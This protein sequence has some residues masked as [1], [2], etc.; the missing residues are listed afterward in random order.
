MCLGRWMDRLFMY[1]CVNVGVC[2]Q[3]LWN[4][5]CWHIAAIR[6]YA[7]ANVHTCVR[8]AC[9]LHA[10]HDTTKCT[11]KAQSLINSARKQLFVKVL[12]SL[13]IIAFRHG[14]CATVL[15]RPPTLYCVLPIACYV[16]DTK[17][18]YSELIWILMHEWMNEWMHNG[19]VR[20]RR[21]LSQCQAYPMRTWAKKRT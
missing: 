20:P 11:Q 21:A 17:F 3:Y 6:I 8:C 7:C 9:G 16:V 1:V 10:A 2:V 19:Q 4:E 5:R 15:A 14:L 18:M 13:P 12:F